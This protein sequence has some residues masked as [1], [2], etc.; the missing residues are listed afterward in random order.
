M[1]REKQR[2]K[3]WHEQAERAREDA[4]QKPPAP[5]AVGIRPAGSPTSLDAIFGTPR[6]K[7]G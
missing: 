4:E 7:R 6:K 2:N 1:I 3:R 5:H